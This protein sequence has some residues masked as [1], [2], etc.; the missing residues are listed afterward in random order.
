M[1]LELIVGHVELP[2]GTLPGVSDTVASPRIRHVD[3][4]LIRA[5]DRVG[6]EAG[7][8]DRLFLSVDQDRRLGFEKRLGGDGA[9]GRVG[10]LNVCGGGHQRGG[11]DA[12]MP[13]QR[14]ECLRAEPGLCASFV[15]LVDAA[16]V[17]LREGGFQDRIDARG[18]L[19]CS[20]RVHVG[21]EDGVG[22]EGVGVAR[23]GGEGHVEAIDL[24]R[25][26]AVYLD[27]GSQ[28]IPA[29]LAL[30]QGEDGR[31][32]IAV[33]NLA[34]REREIVVVVALDDGGERVELLLRESLL[35]REWD[36]V[37]GHEGLDAE[38]LSQDR[39]TFGSVLLELGELFLVV[40]FEAL[41]L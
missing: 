7:D 6:V 35:L 32:E 16:G 24:S 36:I 38:G 10:L 30:G 9:L 28:M 4:V 3:A 22:S 23:G 18:V 40:V 27:E 1:L 34:L 15:P 39:R 25:G 12:E 31:E 14:V 26:V 21:D 8:R 13:R 33:T 19:G 17:A 11:W 2:S 37:A 20:P 5:R 29:R 41:E